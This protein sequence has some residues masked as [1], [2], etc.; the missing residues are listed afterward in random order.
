M[1]I[2]TREPL[3]YSLVFCPPASLTSLC[4]FI[5]YPD[6]AA[7]PHR[8]SNFLSSRR[9]LRP[10]DLRGNHRIVWHSRATSEILDTPEHQQQPLAKKKEKKKETRENDRETS[11]G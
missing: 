3:M 9:P 7:R 1:S 8:F 4:H 2:C 11:M 6:R 5:S 10:P